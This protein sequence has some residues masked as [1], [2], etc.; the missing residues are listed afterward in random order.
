[1][2]LLNGFGVVICGMSLLLGIIELSTQKWI[3]PP[4]QKTF[5][6]IRL[7][8]T[9]YQTIFVP[10]LGAMV[11]GLF[12]SLAA[13][14]FYLALT[15]KEDQGSWPQW[16]GSSL[17]I[18]GA[19][20]LTIT[21]RAA[22]KGVGE[23]GELARDPFTIRAAAE[24]YAADPL[25][26]TLDPTFLDKNLTEWEAFIATRAM[27]ISSTR[28]ENKSSTGDESVSSE[29]KSARLHE[30]LDD[31]AKAKSFF[32]CIG[33]S[34]CVYFAA[35]CRFPFRFMWPFLGP[36]FL[37]VGIG[38]AT[39]TE[40]K[41]DSDSSFHA[42]AVIVGSVALAVTIVL[43]TTALPTLIYFAARGNRARR[44]HRVNLTAVEEARESI[45][46]ARQAYESIKVENAMIKRVLQSADNFLK[47]P[48]PATEV[49]PERALVLGALRVSITWRSIPKAGRG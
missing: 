18:A 49:Q 19:I 24:E 39:F 6:Y 42:C 32:P 17:F 30:V 44:W 8:A 23:P 46:T 13:S 48:I 47:R 12:V 29:D 22:F 34:I 16:V 26:G 38:L 43:V 28:D 31:A 14:F 27:N 10:A 3:R 1:M 4:A 45:S 5:T 33:H 7:A 40:V 20:A 41:I 15:A 25:R 35:L 37:A 21:L 36:L 2:T 11:S 9:Q